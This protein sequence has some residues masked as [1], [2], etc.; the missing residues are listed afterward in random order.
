MK[1]EKKAARFLTY[2]ILTAVAAI[3]LFPIIYV[4]SA[5]FKS[6][7]EIMVHPEHLFPVEPT[8]DNY[9]QAWNSGN[10][11]IGNMLWNSLYYSVICVVITMITSSMGGYVFSRGDFP[12][13]KIVFAVFSSLM[14][15]SIGSITIYPLFDILDIFGLAHSLWGLIVMKMFG[16]S[17]I[18]VYLVR[19]YVNTLPKALD[20]A[21]KIDGCSFFGTFARIVLPLTKPIMATVG[22]LAFQGSWNEYLLPTIFTLTRPEQRT[23]IVGV[24]ALK[25]SGHAAASWNLMLAGTTVALIPVL[26]AYAVGNKYFVSGIAAGA[27][28]G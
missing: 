18:N 22:I 28:K 11:Q 14:F 8:L 12:G 25:N 17:I 10:F 20:E 23:L 26:L 6:N 3:A 27:V 1:I 7:S 19:S 24:V 13:K 15:V 16:V 21:A 4:I 5:S 9:K 2:F